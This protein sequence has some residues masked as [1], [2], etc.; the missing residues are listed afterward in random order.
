M[1]QIQLLSKEARQ[2][3]KSCKQLFNKKNRPEQK[4][5]K[6]EKGSPNHHKGDEPFNGASSP[7]LDLEIVRLCKEREAA[8]L[9]CKEKREKEGDDTRH[10]HLLRLKDI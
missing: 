5:E 10:P 7:W 4:G 1:I 2:A 3:E 6:K 8:W 9:L